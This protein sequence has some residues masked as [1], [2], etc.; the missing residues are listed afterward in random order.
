MEPAAEV[1]FDEMI[2]KNLSP[3]QLRQFNKIHYG[4]ED[5]NEVKLKETTAVSASEKN[6]FQVQAYAFAA[7]KEETRNPRILKIG[8]VQ[9]SIVLPTNKPA[10]EQREAIFKKI[11]ELIDIAASEGVQI[12]CLQEAWSSPFF[13]CTGEKKQWDEFIESPTNGP[14]TKF[15]A[16]LAK[17]YGMVIISPIF[18]RDDSG[19]MW[20]TAVVIDDTGTFLGKHR[21]NHLPSIGS[22]SEAGYYEPGNTGHA[23]FET[24]YAKFAINICY[25]RHQALNWLMFGLNGAEVVFN[26]AATIAE[27]GESFWGI[28]AR[29]AAVANSYFTAG[30][31]R[32]GSESFTVIK[33]D[34]EK[35]ICRT[36][37]GS[38]YVT[39]PN[40]CRT[41]SLSRVKDGLLMA[42]LDLN[43]CR[44]VKD[45]WGFGM[46]ARLDMYANELKNK[47]GYT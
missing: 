17:K 9:H 26:P 39:A 19:V 30:V 6:N 46:T 22:F 13:L 21:K 20:N 4:R 15:L 24:R 42:E 45:H 44:Q 2:Q 40:G 38:S 5:H 37:Y 8:L 41:P 12:L 29:N 27:F 47:I 7:A 33:D 3:E 28:E 11:G 35:K 18:E 34:E 10:N 32:V 25:G 43:L 36:Y 14:S 1:Y 31:N 23:V 16:P